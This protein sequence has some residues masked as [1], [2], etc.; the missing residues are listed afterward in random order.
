VI[1]FLL[2]DGT[3]KVPLD[4]R[5][6]G[7]YPKHI[8]DFTEIDKAKEKYG[9]NYVGAYD[10]HQFEIYNKN[11]SIMSKYS[12]EQLWEMSIAGKNGNTYMFGIEE[13]KQPLEYRKYMRAI[14][15]L[16]AYNENEKGDTRYIIG[17]KDPSDNANLLH[18]ALLYNC[19]IVYSGL[20]LKNMK[21]SELRK[22]Y[23]SMI[24]Q[25]IS[26]YPEFDSKEFQPLLEYFEK[27]LS[28]YSQKSFVNRLFKK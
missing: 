21:S 16:L 9:S 24:K 13:S 25:I 12:Y 6:N 1:V 15:L 10:Y 19:S 4:V 23:D 14:S 28:N 5:D 27:E 22:M 18:D 26:L 2:S 7:A 8:K 11:I 3:F 20:Q 17:Q